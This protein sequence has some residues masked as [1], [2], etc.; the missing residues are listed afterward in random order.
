MMDEIFI[1]YLS[2]HV[3]VAG[4]GAVLARM[5]VYDS[6]LCVITSH[7]SSGDNEG[8]ELRRNLDYSEIYRRA[9]FP[10]EIGPHNIE[11]LMVPPEGLPLQAPPEGTLR[12]NEVYMYFWITRLSC[13]DGTLMIIARMS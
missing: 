7:L 1:C 8:D 13:M 5:R 10:E 3:F 2:L 12:V 11:H 4:L 9:E 6:P